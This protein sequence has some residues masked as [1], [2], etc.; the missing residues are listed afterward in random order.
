M[1]GS[2]YWGQLTFDIYYGICCS[3]AASGFFCWCI[4]GMASLSV[5]IEVANV[6]S[7]FASIVMDYPIYEGLNPFSVG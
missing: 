6:T 7:I 5:D 1:T 3:S 2:S 4:T